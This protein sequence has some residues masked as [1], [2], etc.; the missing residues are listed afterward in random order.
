MIKTCLN[1]G[2]EYNASHSSQKYC[3]PLYYRINVQVQMQKL[4][5]QKVSM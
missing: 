2:K 1:C 4:V 5:E 3:S